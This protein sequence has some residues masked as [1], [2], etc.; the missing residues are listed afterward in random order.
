VED[1]MRKWV[2]VSAPA[3][4]V[5]GTSSVVNPVSSH[6]HRVVAR[7]DAGEPE[8]AALTADYRDGIERHS[9]AW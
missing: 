9:C 8:Q 1:P 6:G 3:V 4:I 7:R 2:G 5:T